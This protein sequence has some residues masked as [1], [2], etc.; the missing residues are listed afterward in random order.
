MGSKTVFEI[1]C[2]CAAICLCPLSS[3]LSM[4]LAFR[5]VAAKIFFIF[6]FTCI[7]PFVEIFYTSEDRFRLF[8]CMYV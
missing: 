2:T 5:S 3:I 8:D 4:I 6:M 1:F 7:V